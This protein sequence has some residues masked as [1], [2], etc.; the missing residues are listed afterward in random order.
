MS[1][2]TVEPSL[3]CVCVYIVRPKNLCILC[4]PAFKENTKLPMRLRM[5]CKIY[6]LARGSLMHIFNHRYCKQNF[7]EQIFFFHFRQQLEVLLA[8]LQ[9]LATMKRDN[10]GDWMPY[11]GCLLVAAF[12]KIVSCL[13]NSNFL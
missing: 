3:I 9:R 1:E 12:V 5:K 7:S 4:V 10:D 8:T 6:L 11:H 2:H 13:A